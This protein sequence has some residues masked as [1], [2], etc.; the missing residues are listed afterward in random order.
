MI[1]VVLPFH[2]KNLARVQGAVELD[3]PPP[4]TTR[5]V[6]DALEERY[7]VLRGTI[8]DHG[9]LARRPFL[10]FYVCEE[11]WS[12]ESPDAPLPDAVASGAEPFLVIGAIAGGSRRA[13]GPMVDDLERAAARLAG[14]RRIV[15]LTGAGSSAESGV[16]TFRGPGGLWRSF[17]PEDLATSEAFRRDP[18]LVWE[19]YAWRRERVAAAEPHAGHR[20]LV[21][22]E[23]SGRLERIVTQNVDGLHQRA[24]SARVI[25]LHGSLWTVRCTRCGNEREDRTLGERALPPPCPA[26][27]GAERPGVVWFGESLPERAFESAALAVREADALLVV[28]TSAQVEPAASLVFEAD[29]ERAVV[30]EINPAAT[31]LG[32]VVDFAL[33]GAAGDVLP[34]L[35]ATGARPAPG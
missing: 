29:R 7:P 6:L 10:R 20:T 3:V 16:P 24:G 26:C 32:D 35:F 18:V 21:E 11:D 8:R 13:E 19:W 15:A 12:L 14:A 23:R 33:R 2:L 30:V 17:R 4:A 5:R 28:G 34:A 9:T 27:G 31:S 22:L 1:R 25:E